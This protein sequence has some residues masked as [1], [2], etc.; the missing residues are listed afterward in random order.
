[1]WVRIAE[2]PFEAH[3]LMN[4]CD[5]NMLIR[6]PVETGRLAV[7]GICEKVGKIC[8]SSL[9]VLL[10]ACGS[11]DRLTEPSGTAPPGYVGSES[12]KSCHEKQFSDWDHS[13][14][15]LAMQPAT[16]ET[17]V[18]DF[19]D[20]NFKYAGIEYGFSRRDGKFFALA[21]DSNGD[22]REFEISHTFGVEPLQQYLVT[23]A[24]GRRQALGVAW[25][26]RPGDE[27]GQRWFHLYPDE[28]ITHDDELHWAGRNQNW[29]Y[30]CAD[31]HS[32]DLR[33]NYEPT[34]KSYAT[35]WAEI[36]VGCE[37]WWARRPR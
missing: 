21:D 30:M 6:S 13:Q 20:T 37:A 3:R 27:G 17:V 16:P 24:D 11:D 22:I 19:D 5:A 1:M 9:Y 36:C 35:S 25:D 8:V 28:T 14:H 26:T 15:F 34:R 4:Q 33:K 31:C 32:T 12:C 7:V 10:V 29:N 2:Q 23:F 18:G